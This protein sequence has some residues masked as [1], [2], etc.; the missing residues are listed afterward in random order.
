MRLK[1]EQ[2]R[3]I[4]LSDVTDMA[5]KQGLFKTTLKA[6][7]DKRKV[8]LS[9]VRY[10]FRTNTELWRAIIA[11]GSAAEKVMTDARKIGLI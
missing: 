4:I 8:S 9:T 10:C 2:R 11:S 5:N 7:A 6:Y 3:N 1:Q